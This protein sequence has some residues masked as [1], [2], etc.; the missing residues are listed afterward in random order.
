[1]RG[2]DPGGRRLAARLG[3]VGY[4]TGG[5]LGG[6]RRLAAL[7]VAA[8]G[9]PAAAHAAALRRFTRSKLARAAPG[10]EPA[11]PRRTGSPRR[12]QHWGPW[13]IQAIRSEP[14]PGTLTLA[15]EN[16]LGSLVLTVAIVRY[17]PP[18]E[19]PLDPGRCVAPLPAGRQHP[20]DEHRRA[21]ADA[22]A[23]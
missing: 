12:Q 7:G 5:A 1:M 6:L 15:L 14:V 18:G 3:G 20:P 4:R 9:A 8:S 22:G 10:S 13:S 11:H 21:L 17:G 16:P 23:G 19:L 2:W